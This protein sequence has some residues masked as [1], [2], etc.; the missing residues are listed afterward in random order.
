MSNVD[1]SDLF[2]LEGEVVLVTGASSGLG[3][4][5]ARVLTAAGASVVVGARRADRLESLVAELKEEGGAALA[6]ALDVT[7]PESVENC[8]ATVEH[9]F[10][11]VTVLINNAGVADSRYCLNV[12][13]D[14]WDFVMDTNLK[15]AWRM[16]QAVAQRCV[17]AECPGS[18]VNIASILGLRVGFGESTYATAKA[19]L[20]QL[21]K[22]MALELGTKGVRVNALCPGYFVTEMNADFLASKAG[23]TMLERSA[24]RRAG[25]MSELNG[26]LLL[27]AS[28]AGSFMTGVALPVDGGHLVS[29]L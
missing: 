18:I 2:S 13:E 29:S 16:A 1:T 8:L 22:A 20:V 9:A 11:T 6:V 24:L 3:A 5:F 26:P 28:L 12:D 15:G 25:D 21:T 7:S 27:L 17:K 14:S 23:K 4:H 10:G 19:A